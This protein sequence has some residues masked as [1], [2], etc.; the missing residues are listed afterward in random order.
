MEDNVRLWTLHRD[1][2]LCC[3]WAGG[4]VTD[5]G[6][7]HKGIGQPSERTLGSDE[8]ELPPYGKPF[9][10]NDFQLAGLDL[11]PNRML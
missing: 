4:S 8:Q 10:V 6:E 11:P 9:D 3:R 2:M 1:I 7:P 5:R